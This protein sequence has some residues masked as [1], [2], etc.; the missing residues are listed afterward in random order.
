MPGEIIHLFTGVGIFI[1]AEFY[2]RYKFKND[3]KKRDHILLFGVSILF[4]VIPD[5]PLGLYYIFNISSKHILLG[6]HILLHQIIT[7]VSFV[8]LLFLLFFKKSKT[9]IIWIVGLICILVHIAMDL[10]IHEGGIWI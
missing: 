7:S 4:S 10:Y 1:A 5:F 2:L 9:S 3:L 8:L 6:Y